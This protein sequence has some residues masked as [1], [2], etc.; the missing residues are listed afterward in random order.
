MSLPLSCA[1]RRRPGV[2]KGP[3][4]SDSGHEAVV[5]PVSHPA[6]R[7]RL[8]TGHA[9]C[10]V[11]SGRHSEMSPV[12]NYCLPT[13]EMGGRGSSRARGANIDEMCRHSVLAAAPVSVRP[14]AEVCGAGSAGP[15]TRRYWR[16][17]RGRVI[18]E[19]LLAMVMSAGLGSMASAAAEWPVRGSWRNVWCI[20]AAQW[21]NVSAPWQS[22]R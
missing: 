14:R 11:H 9:R 20:S 10:F 21:R 6:R 1:L 7:T 18:D 4:S 19:A 12:T 5:L 15:L 13:A 16:L 2:G 8:E 3:T 22:E 17:R